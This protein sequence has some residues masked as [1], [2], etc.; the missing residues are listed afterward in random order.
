MPGSY[1]SPAPQDLPPL[2][3][4]ELRELFEHLDTRS[5]CDHTF[6]HTTQFLER[7]D[8]ATEPVLAWL[9]MNG[10]GCD[11]EVIFNV[12]ANWDAWA[13]SPE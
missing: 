13:L 3:K 6:A 8:I 4:H 7:R 1:L 5:T 11:C 10:A 12:A 2:K 9:Q